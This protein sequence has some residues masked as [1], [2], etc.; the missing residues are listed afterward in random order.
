MTLLLENPLPIWSAGAVLTAICLVLVFA[1]RSLS[2]VVALIAVIAITLALAFVESLVITEREQVEE[3]LDQ[4]IDALEAND[5]AAVLAVVDPSANVVRSDA[6]ALMSQVNIADAGATGIRIELDDS[7][8]PPRAMALFRG[9]IDGVHTRTGARVFFFDQVEIDWQKSG[10]RWLILNY[11]VF[12]R[13]EAID[14]VRSVHGN[15]PV[16]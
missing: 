1:R 15:R 13:G 6:E 10:E 2:S 14:A 9:R 11:R 7:A 5:L 8:K 3:S 4:L 16:R 12:Q